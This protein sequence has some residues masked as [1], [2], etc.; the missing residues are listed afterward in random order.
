M[1][2]IFIENKGREERHF[3][4]IHFHVFNI[5]VWKPVSVTELKRKKA[6]VTF[7]LTIWTFWRKIARY[8][9]NSKNFL[10]ILGLYLTFVFVLFQ[11]WNK[12]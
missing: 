9:Q 8:K 11:P 1:F 6:I 2:F 10:T 4:A 7:Y 12:K 5:Y 3:Y